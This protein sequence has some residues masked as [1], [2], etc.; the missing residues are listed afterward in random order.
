[1]R[2]IEV[3][4]NQLEL[5]CKA[6][7]S[8]KEVAAALGIS[9]NAVYDLCIRYGVESP[10]ERKKRLEKEAK[11]GKKRGSDL[12]DPLFEEHGVSGT[13]RK[14]SPEEAEARIALQPPIRRV[15][16]AEY[17]PPPILDVIETYRE[18]HYDMIDKNK[19]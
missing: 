17:Q 4:K 6:S 18:K 16:V 10:W 7:L 1:M 9:G 12:P 5:L 2:K 15:P 13:T 19:S 3:D 8:N 14:Q 11:T